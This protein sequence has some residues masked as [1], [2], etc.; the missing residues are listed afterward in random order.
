[1]AADAAS[2]HG[3]HDAGGHGEMEEMVENNTRLGVWVFLGSECA[4]FASLIG[5]YVAVHGAWAPGLGPKQVFDLPLTGTATFALLASSL[6]MALAVTAA[7][8]ND[9]ARMRT[10]LVVTAILGL[11]F[12]GAQVY[13][14][15][16]FYH[17]GLT[18]H[19]SLF[20]ASFFV[21]TGFHGL[22]VSFGIAWIIAMLVY[23][24]RHKGPLGRNAAVRLEVLGLYWAFVDVVWIVI[25]TVVYI[26]GTA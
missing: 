1:M 15:T 2:L 20:G 11:M 10:L 25:F 13:E 12:V 7:G 16:D 8:R 14:F 18:L 23:S 3:V 22:H 21:L 26:L 5:T 19:S 4:F 9:F 17:K 6:T 24:Y